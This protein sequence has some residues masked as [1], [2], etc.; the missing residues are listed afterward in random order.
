MSTQHSAVGSQERGT[1]SPLSALRSQQQ[2]SCL[3][4]GS[5]SLVNEEQ[6]TRNKE[7][8]ECDQ[9]LATN[10][11]GL[12]LNSPIMT[13]SGTYGYG[14][15]FAHFYDLNLLGAIVVKGIT[16]NPRAGNPGQR[17]IETPA[18]LINS[19]GLENPGVEGFIAQEMPFLL[20]AGVPV[21]IN[22]SGNTPEEYAALAE[23]LSEEPGITALEVNISCPNVKQGGMAFGAS[24]DMAAAVTKDVRK[25]TKLPIIVKLSPNVTDIASIAQAI[26]AEGADGI[27]LINTLLGMGIDIH[28][29]KPYLNNT[30]G[31]LSGP[32]IKPVALRMVWQVAGAVKVPVIG[33]GGISTWQDAVEFL[34]AGASAVAVGTANL[35]NPMAVPEIVAG[36][37]Q[38]LQEQ[39]LDNVQQLVGAARPN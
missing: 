33:M 17:L 4:P 38:Y 18:G 39:G 11:F 25:R 5:S 13:A 9:R 14:K 35:F 15:E 1:G 21:I 22:M 12:T 20:N 31:G 32:A 34:L 30:F 36:L 19:I 16:M 37:E 29:K 23:R 26:E 3:V 2:K 27:S 24:C 8:H 6:G 28:K 10:L 7:R